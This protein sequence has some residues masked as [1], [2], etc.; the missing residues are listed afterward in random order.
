MLEEELGEVIVD[1]VVDEARRLRLSVRSW[2]LRRVKGVLRGNVGKEGLEG[3]REGGTRE[4]GRR[5]EDTARRVI[6]WIFAS[7]D[8]PGMNCDLVLL[9]HCNESPKD[10]VDLGITAAE[11]LPRAN[12]AFIVAVYAYV[13]T[14]WG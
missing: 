5:R 1:S 13:R 8:V 7:L 6:R 4:T 12:D 9:T 10:S 11:M 2:R 3:V 14:R